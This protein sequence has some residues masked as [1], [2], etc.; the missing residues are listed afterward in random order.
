MAVASL[1]E[2]CSNAELEQT[3]VKRG[4]IDAARRRQRLHGKKPTP[5]VEAGAGGALTKPRHK[6]CKPQA[7]GVSVISIHLKGMFR[8]PNSCD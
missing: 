7:Q 1:V 3:L 8:R 4:G 2:N 5:E 6:T